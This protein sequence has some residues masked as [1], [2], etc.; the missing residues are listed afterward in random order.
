MHYYHS[1]IALIA[2][3]FSQATVVMQ[4]CYSSTII[5]RHNPHGHRVRIEVNDGED[6]Q[7]VSQWQLSLLLPEGFNDRNSILCF[8]APVAPTD[9]NS[10]AI[11]VTNDQNNHCYQLAI[12]TEEQIPASQYASQRVSENGTL[13]RLKSTTADRPE[14]ISV[15]IDPLLNGKPCATS[16]TLL[17]Y[18]NNIR[19]GMET[20]QARNNRLIGG[21][22]AGIADF[23]SGGNEVGSIRSHPPLL[24][25]GMSSGSFETDLIILKS[26]ITWLRS[27]GK[28]STSFE[29]Q[30]SPAR[31][32]ITRVN[33]DGSSSEAAIPVG[34]LDFLDIRQLTDVDF[35]NTLFQRAV[36]SC[37]ASESLQWQLG[38]FKLLLER[39]VFKT[40]HGGGLKAGNGDGKSSGSAP[41]AKPKNENNDHQKEQRG[42]PE[43][44]ENPSPG[45]GSEGSG[46]GNNRKDDDGE[47]SEKNATAQDIKVIASRLVAIIESEDRDAVFKLRQIL[48]EL[49][50]PQRLQVLETKS[51]NTRGDPLTPLEAVLELQRSSRENSLRNRFIE[52]LIEATSDKK[53]TLN[54]LGILSSL[55]PIISA[56]EAQPRVGENNLVIL[57]KIV[58]DII[59]KVNQPGQQS[60]IGQFEK[61]CFA[62]YFVQL[63]LRYSNPVELIRNLLGEISD[64]VIS[65]DIMVYAQLFTFSTSLSGTFR[66]FDQHPSS[67]ELIHFTDKLCMQMQSCSLPQETVIS[68]S[69]NTSNEIIA[70]NA[71]TFTDPV[72]QVDSYRSASGFAGSSSESPS[73]KYLQQGARPKKQPNLA[74]NEDGRP[75][76][77]GSENLNRDLN[78]LERIVGKYHS[79]IKDIEPKRSAKEKERK[80]RQHIERQQAEE[81]TEKVQRLTIENQNLTADDQRFWGRV[82]CLETENQRLRE[83]IEKVEDELRK[84]QELVEFMIHQALQQLTAAISAMSDNGPGH[85]TSCQQ[86]SPYNLGANPLDEE[87]PLPQQETLQPLCEHYHRR[88]LV[89]FNCCGLYFPCHRCHN[90]NDRCQTTNSSG[91]D[92]THLLCILCKYK[93]E[94]TEGSQ[95]CPECNERMSDFYC[96]KC[97]LFTAAVLNPFHCDKCGICRIYEDKTYHCDVCNVCLDKRLKGDHI[98]RPD[99]GHDEC[100]ICLED[101]FTGCLILPCSHKVHK[102]C[103]VAMIENRV[104][105]CPVCRYPLN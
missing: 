85:F 79:L 60:P 72:R 33:A 7:D 39:T 24:S 63:F 22:L 47:K 95:I 56:D 71:N 96:A 97:K 81:L 34:C 49:N 80:K 41:N 17:A 74:D 40:N 35:W 42:E 78:K 48:D 46:N 11:L 10:I 67:R 91:V 77:H 50:M 36:T 44:Q 13:V 58:Q 38:C 31:M 101:V 64:S 26:L 21:K 93:G 82:A 43:G 53:Q 66:R 92:A 61:C 100:C 76:D 4:L 103:G 62:E 27:T 25:G 68:N 102:E 1:F 45:E 19:S 65:R 84:Q 9:S 94:I 87:L 98:C 16:L 105:S 73:D 57:H 23:P 55:Q 37:P 18:S 54:D 99:S 32:K 89:R 90:E 15:T 30:L 59:L 75:D 70:G 14:L 29:E 83:H 6:L 52:Q 69:D 86:S 3:V 12:T 2:F 20:G 104:R 8:K 88:C 51:T 28:D 5:E